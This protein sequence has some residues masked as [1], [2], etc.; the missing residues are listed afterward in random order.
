MKQIGE[1]R[2]LEALWFMAA[3]CLKRE[4]KYIARKE[5]WFSLFILSVAIGLAGIFVG[6]RPSVPPPDLTP[7]T[8]SAAPNI[9]SILPNNAACVVE[10]ARWGN[11]SVL[12][13]TYSP[14]GR[15]MALVTS[16]GVYIHETET[17]ALLRTFETDLDQYSVAFSPDWTT[18]A[19]A[20]GN[21]IR[22]LRLSDGN[23][24]RTLTEQP[25]TETRLVFSPDG[26]LLA[27]LLFPPG[28]E[29]YT[30]AVELW[31][32][33]DGALLNT[34]DSLGDHMAFSPDG[35]MLAS[36]HTMTGI[37]VWRVPDGKLL[38]TLEDWIND[39][40]FSPDG[41][42]LAFA[43]GDAVRLWRVSDWTL[44]REVEGNTLDTAIRA[45]FSPDGTMLASISY[46]GRVQLWQ[47]ADGKSLASFGPGSG[48]CYGALAF[49]PDSQTLVS[50]AMDLQFWRVP[51]GTSIRILE[52]Y[53]PPVRS[54]AISPDGR[55]ITAV[56]E[57][58]SA[59]G[60]NVR[61]WRVSDGSARALAEGGE[62][63]SV[64]YSP[65]GAHLALGMWDGTVWLWQLSDDKLLHTMER[66]SA[67]VQSVAFSPDGKLLASSAMGE[68]RLWQVG[69]GT[70]LRTLEPSGAGWME[71]AAF[72]PDGD[73]L[74]SFSNG[75]VWLWQMPDGA[76]VNSFETE[77]DG[78]AGSVAFSPDSAALA[79]GKHDKVLVWQVADGKLL[80]TL[81]VPAGVSSIVFSPDGSL[82]VSAS[83]DT[84]QLWRVSDG[85]LLH[86]LAGHTGVV[87][88]VAFSADGR[89]IASGSWDGTVRLWGVSGS[90][91]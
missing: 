58:P 10:L 45:A 78:Y 44:L 62:A 42:I 51:D 41:E 20:S 48:T 64:A 57:G 17:M 2:N 21:E 37:R 38:Y 33:A 75:K 76:L 88:S 90:T 79:L 87:T 7:V 16:L 47:V 82:L 46:T 27:S 8:P 1:K 49:S 15:Q 53:I 73:F 40:A 54:V 85:S 55:T 3:I 81:D 28:D 39:A 34:W 9:G 65:D 13:V 22:L 18:L 36:W 63:L 24:L 71:S 61:L 83:G 14:H 4:R 5:K 89:F 60:S 86:T 11:G 43:T 72:S 66:H 59:A 19:W 91:R 30:G 23:L 74:A 35:R 67:Q 50:A 25:G 68:V 69:D 6:C 26:S 52:G 29:V 12:Q 84:V 70:L 80:R 31:R 56:S 32:V 77:D